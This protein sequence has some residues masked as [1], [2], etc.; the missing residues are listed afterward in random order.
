MRRLRPGMGRWP[1]HD[2]MWQIAFS[3]SVTAVTVS[4]IPCALLAL[5][6]CHSPPRGGLRFSHQ[7]WYCFCLALSLET[8]TS[9][10][11]L[12]RLEKVQ[13][14]W[15]GHVQMW[16]TAPVRTSYWICKSRA[17]WKRRASYSKMK[18]LNGSGA[19]DQQRALLSVGPCAATQVTPHEVPESTA[20][21]L[22]EKAF[23]MT[24]APATDCN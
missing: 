7:S 5:W 11:Q 3:T 10:T 15:R 9:G 14:T 20:W 4:P 19:S 12:S 8:L 17:K 6:P 21:N 13:A 22:S 24:P 2:Q 23:K 18:A 1:A 16:P